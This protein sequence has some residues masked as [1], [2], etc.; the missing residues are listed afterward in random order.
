MNVKPTELEA[1]YKIVLI[2]DSDVG[3]TS[4]L[5]RY[6]NDIFN[7]NPATVGIDF[8][9]KTLKVDNHMIKL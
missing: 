7:P 1:M 2:G 4:I 8:K 9:I 5:L 3:K 6:S